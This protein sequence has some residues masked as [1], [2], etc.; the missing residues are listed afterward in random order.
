MQLMIKKAFIMV[1][2][3]VMLLALAELQVRAAGTS[4]IS[5]ADFL[6][7]GIGS[8]PLG[9]G[10]AFT[11]E[12]NDVNAIYFNPAGLGSMKYPMLSMNHQELITDTRLENISAAFPL[13]GGFLGVSNTMFWVPPF[14]KIDIS[15]AKTGEVTYYNGAATAAYGYDLEFMYVGGAVKYVYQRIDTLFVHSAAVDIGILKGLTMPSPFEAPIRNFHL[16][17]C[18][19]NIGTKAKDDPLPRTLRIGMSYKFTKWLGLNI[20]VIENFIDIS[21]LYDFTYGFDESLRVCTGVEATYMELVSLRAGYQFVNGW[22]PGEGGNYSMGIGLNYV[23]SNVTFNIDTSYADAGVFG[24]VYTINISFK[25]IPKVVTI[26][27]RLDAEYYYN[28]GIKSFV[29]NDIESAINEFK[30]CKDYNP[31][32]KNID[33]KIEDLEEIIRLQQ[34]NIKLDKELKELEKEDNR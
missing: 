23:V 6:E 25:L 8:R 1:F 4:G 33:R 30:T 27:D 3:A 34:E 31:Y 17:L 32:H 28:R 14:D 9:M 10:E 16:G 15:G 24:A 26:Q 21:D 13:Y 7:I 11:A 18:L 20:D 12:V 22:D 2:S 5:G 29:A 19:Q